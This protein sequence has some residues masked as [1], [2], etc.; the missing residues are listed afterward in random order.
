[1]SVID[2]NLVNGKF[3]CQCDYCNNIF[4][5]FSKDRIRFIKNPNRKCF[6][7]NECAGNHKNKRISLNCKQCNKIFIKEFC[8]IK[9]SK[10]GNHFCSRSCAGTYNNAHRKHIKKH[11]TR[12]SKLE[13]WIERQLLETYPDLEFHFNRKDAINSELDIYIPS[14]KLA[15]ELNGIFHYEPIFGKEKLAKIQNNDN[16]KF[17]A[18]HEAD[19]SLCIIDVSQQKYCKPKTSQKYLDIITEIIDNV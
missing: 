7:N 1:M 13:N 18:C 6:C 3:K 4:Y 17:Q 19:I 11:G 2:I 15:F 8:R 12:R 14:L 10:S 9:K 5:K 16:R